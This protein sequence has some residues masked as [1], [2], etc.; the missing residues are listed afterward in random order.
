ML[1]NYKMQFLDLKAQYKSIKKE[2]NQA[3]LK[4]LNEGDFIL[5]S[6]VKKLEYDISRYCKTKYG[7]GVN[8]GTDALYLSLMA[9]GVGPDDE[10][11]VPPFS[12]IATVDVVA[13]LGA[14]PVFVDIN[15]KTF[16]IDENKIEEKISK[17]TKAIIPVHIFGRP[18]EIDRIMEIAKKYNLFVIEDAAQAIGAKY[19]GRQI[20]SIGHLGCFSFFPSK[21]LGAYGDGGMIVTNDDLLAKKIQALRVHG[22]FKKYHHDLLGINSRLDNLQAAILR[23]KLKYLNSWVKKR[24]KVASIYTKGLKKVTGIIAPDNYGDKNISTHV[25]HQYT[26]RAKHRD[27]LQDYLKDNGIPTMVYYPLAL[28]L[29]TVFKNLGYKDGNMPESEKATQEV[30]SLP[31]YPELDAKKQKIII[32]KIKEFYKNHQ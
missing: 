14:K 22:S 3:V 26:I 5:G 29:Q 6:E 18:V 9:I 12:F 24:Q 15:P 7:I 17:K 16:N 23:V 10:V 13:L 30:L 27:K 20:G 21:N 2:I 25:Y 31:I 28:H 4:A 32:D 19:K 1:I 8:S 11:I